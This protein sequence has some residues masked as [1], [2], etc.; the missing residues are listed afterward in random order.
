MSEKC[1]FD[2]EVGQVTPREIKQNGSPYL[3]LNGGHLDLMD[4]KGSQYQSYSIEYWFRVD[5]INA[6]DPVL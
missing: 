3:S 1:E 5:E 6:I 4:V 2:I